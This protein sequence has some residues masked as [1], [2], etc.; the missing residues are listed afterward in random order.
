MLTKNKYRISVLYGKLP[1][2]IEFKDKKEFCDLV[3]D[4]AVRRLFS[5]EDISYM[6]NYRGKKLTKQMSKHRD[7]LIGV[8]T[9]MGVPASY[10]GYSKLHISRRQVYN[11][12]YS[13][14]DL[15]VDE[16]EELFKLVKEEVTYTKL[17]VDEGNIKVVNSKFIKELLSISNRGFI[18]LYDIDT[19]KHYKFD[20]KL[21]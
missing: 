1:L 3:F 19:K 14:M 20:V 11:V 8:L 7:I 10:D 16:I 17:G 21:I 4:L 13:R 15:Y 5:E 18:D 6:E 12:R 2:D 9:L